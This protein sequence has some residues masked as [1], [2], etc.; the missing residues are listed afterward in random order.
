VLS[1][2][3]GFAAGGVLGAI[4]AFPIDTTG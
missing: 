3:E 1:R 4:N 2:F